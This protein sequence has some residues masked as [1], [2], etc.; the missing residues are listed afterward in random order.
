MYRNLE[1]RGRKVA[2]APAA[3]EA[4]LQAFFR[5]DDVNVTFPALVG[6]MRTHRS[7]SA[8]AA[9]VGNARL[10]AVSILE[11]GRRRCR[12]RTSDRQK[13]SRKNSGHVSV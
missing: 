3:H 5:S 9:D 13:A 12:N 1:C 10:G 4:M 2:T 8:M 6:V 11:Y 7:F